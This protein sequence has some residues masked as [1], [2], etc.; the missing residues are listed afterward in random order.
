[1]DG[2]V[3]FLQFVAGAVLWG[4]LIYWLVG[5]FRGR[6]A[7]GRRAPRTWAP[8]P[9]DRRAR[10]QDD[11]QAFTDGLIFGYYLHRTGQWPF[12]DHDADAGFDDD[13]DDDPWDDGWSDGDV[14]DDDGPW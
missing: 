8:P 5:V 2:F 9:P 1:M 13:L 11:D 12:A 10:Q 4:L 6:N 3:A 14:E 7:D